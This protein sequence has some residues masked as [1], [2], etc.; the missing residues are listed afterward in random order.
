[1][2]S[3]SIPAYT[4]L[5]VGSRKSPKAPSRSSGQP[6]SASEVDAAEDDGAAQDLVHPDALPQEHDPRADAGQR[7]EVLVH[8]HPVG[9]DAADA[10][11]PGGE[12]ECG[13]QRPRVAERGPGP[14]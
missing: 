13:G 5:P 1:M 8:E 4:A 2:P 6:S 14:D 7:D 9:P 12:G 11:L 10:P 3:R